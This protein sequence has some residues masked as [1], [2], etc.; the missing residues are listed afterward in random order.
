MQDV[1][2]RYSALA[3]EFKTLQQSHKQ[4]AAE[5]QSAQ[6]VSAATHCSALMQFGMCGVCPASA[7]HPA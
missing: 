7:V 4:Q 6:Q 2:R 5:L 3:D 1:E